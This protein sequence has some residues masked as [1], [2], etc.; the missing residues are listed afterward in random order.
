MRL[1]VET[2]S[3]DEKFEKLECLTVQTSS[4]RGRKELTCFKGLVKLRSRPQVKVLPDIWI[5]GPII[6]DDSDDFPFFKTCV[7]FVWF[8]TGWVILQ[9]NDN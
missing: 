2:K 6:S 8:Y 3:D 4:M 1:D 5:D 9:W 7:K